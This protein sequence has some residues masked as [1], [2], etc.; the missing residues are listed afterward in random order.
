MHLR[1]TRMV[2]A[3]KRHSSRSLPGHGDRVPRSFVSIEK[4]RPESSK[5]ER[6]RERGQDRVSR[7]SLREGRR[8][9]EGGWKGRGIAFGSW[10]RGGRTKG[11]KRWR[12]RGRATDRKGASRCR[13][14]RVT[15]SEG[16]KI[17]LSESESI[18]CPWERVPTLPSAQRT[19]RQ[20]LVNV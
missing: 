2:D 8:T 16:P 11:K 7:F 12:A 1:S 9:I 15:G 13:K 14:S 17:W 18:L 20:R 5:K 3:S 10:W 19:E 4:C 6:E